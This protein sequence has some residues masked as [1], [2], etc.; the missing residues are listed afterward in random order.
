MIVD[1]K[2]NFYGDLFID[3]LINCSCVML[4]GRSGNNAFT[5][6]STKGVAVVDYV[7]V[8]HT[9]LHQFEDFKVHTAHNLFNKSALVGKLDPEHNILDHSV[10]SWQF[11]F[12]DYVDNSRSDH[13]FVVNKFDVTQIPD[14]ILTNPF[15]VNV[16]NQIKNTCVA[17]N[18][19]ESYSAF[20][21]IVSPKWRIPCLSNV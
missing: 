12:T 20:C 10:L 9:I 7:F 19:N 8:S 6:I 2:K 5:S 4:N 21:N 3:F 13:S 17:E 11:M 16:M 1:Y 15:V 18:I 14:N